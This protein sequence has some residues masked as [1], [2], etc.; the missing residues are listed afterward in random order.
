[1][2]PVKYEL[3]FISQKTAF[4]IVKK[5]NPWPVVRKRTIPADDRH[6]SA[7]FTANFS[8]RGMSRCQRVICFLDRSRYFS[9]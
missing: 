5:Q 6:L 1:M 9:F 7:K 3:V 8:D 2:S 4:F